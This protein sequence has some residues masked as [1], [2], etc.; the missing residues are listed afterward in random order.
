[1]VVFLELTLD[2][3]VVKEAK[4]IGTFCLFLGFM[5]ELSGILDYIPKLD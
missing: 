1:M 4:I 5:I 3:I 2:N